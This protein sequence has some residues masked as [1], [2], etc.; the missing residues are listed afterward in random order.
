MSAGGRAGRRHEQAGHEPWTR[1]EREYFSRSI[2]FN[3]KGRGAPGGG[4]VDWVG[5][6]AKL[7]A[8]FGNGRTVVG[9]QR[10]YASG[11]IDDESQCDDRPKEDRT[12]WTDDEDALLKRLGPKLGTAGLETWAAIAKHF[13]SRTGQGM[14]GRWRWL[15]SL[16]RSLRKRKT[17]DARSQR[18]ADEH[19]NLSSSDDGGGP[20]GE[21]DYEVDAIVGKRIW[22]GMVQYRV[23]WL[24]YSA[25]ED[26]WEP[27]DH[28]APVTDKVAAFEL[29]FEAKAN[30]AS[31]RQEGIT[32]IG[33][34]PARRKKGKALAG[35]GA[36]APET[37]D[38]ELEVQR[39]IDV[40]LR[41]GDKQ[42]RV[43]WL[44]F[45]DP[46]HDTWEP[47]E[48]LVGSMALVNSFEAH[49]KD[50]GLARALQRQLMG[51]RSAPKNAGGG[52]ATIETD[53]ESTCS[54]R[55][56]GSSR[57]T[58]AARPTERRRRKPASPKKTGASG[59]RTMGAA[60]LKE[61]PAAAGE[62]GGAYART[63]QQRNQ[64]RSSE[65]FGVTKN[66][67]K[68][69]ATIDWRAY[70]MDN[71]Q[72]VLERRFATELEAAR[73]WDAAARR[74]W[75]SGAHGRRRNR[76]GT[77]LK[78][79]WLNFP[80]QEEQNVVAAAAAQPNK[81]PDP[82]EENSAEPESD[83]RAS[84][85][86]K[87]ETGD[88]AAA[89]TTGKGGEGGSGE[90]AGSATA[91]TAGPTFQ[92]H[93]KGAKRAARM[94]ADTRQDAPAAEGKVA[95]DPPHKRARVAA[96]AAGAAAAAATAAA[97]VPPVAAAAPRGRTKILPE[98][99]ERPSQDA[100]GIQASPATPPPVLDQR[101]ASGGQPKQQKAELLCQAGAVYDDGTLPAELREGARNAAVGT[102]VEVAST[103]L[104][105]L[106]SWC[107]GIVTRGYEPQTGTML[108]TY[109]GFAADSGFGLLREEVHVWRV[110]LAH[111]RP[112]AGSLGS[113]ARGAD[114]AAAPQ[115]IVDAF[116]DGLWWEVSHKALPLPC[117]STVFLSKT[118]PFMRSCT[119]HEAL[120]MHPCHADG[121]ELLPDVAGGTLSPRHWKVRF[122][123]HQEDG[124]QV[125][126]SVRHCCLAAVLLHSNCCCLLTVPSRPVP[127]RPAPPRPAPSVCLPF[128]ATLP[129]CPSLR[130]CLSALPC[131]PACSGCER[132]D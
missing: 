69:R 65:Y 18:D 5:Q 78:Q 124:D 43:R 9:A 58:A 94:A 97:A 20:A 2:N 63:R 61:L 10:W 79:V 129:A 37:D 130:P 120:L 131:D 59:S 106:R 118:V 98:E 32:H 119:T 30:S 82:P 71:G 75:G 40:R 110:R 125:S 34:D 13:N 51:M 64:G 4:A 83:E 54:Q 23:R 1:P 55:T 126:I 114:P 25:A 115:T 80:T 66:A 31:R 28:L 60:G 45:P 12:A 35:G 29:D 74:H 24:G 85:G 109:E 46:G 84:R 95:T 36:A 21:G 105:F 128:L 16:D 14:R 3:A 41:F 108:V 127:P 68:H 70:L 107:P 117:V 47:V 86:T 56:L 27:C 62:A 73:A 7:N 11:S 88:E 67:S 121:T 50:E 52:D 103:E 6:V 53:V 8:K 90:A 39:I 89:P 99:Q 17:T 87:G 116:V 112:V 42:Y 26:T 96:T 72:T 123:A 77:G 132:P 33:K 38:G 122:P 111:R 15:C 44:G 91:V 48:N 92:K 113:F 93:I 104:A 19:T 81:E 102:S 49:R 101:S 22:F 76:G 57:L 100:V